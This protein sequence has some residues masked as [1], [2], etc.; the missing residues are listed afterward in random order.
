M[1]TDVH[2]S[3]LAGAPP[4][5][6]NAYRIAAVVL[7]LFALGHTRGALL[8]TPRFGPA[9]DAVAAAMKD[10]HLAAA[11]ASD[12]T[13]YGFY[14]GFGII[15]SVFFL[16]SAVLAWHL[17][18]KTARERAGLWP[19]SAALVASYAANLVIT[20]LYFFPAPTVFSAAVTLL[21]GWGLAS[22]LRAGPREGSAKVA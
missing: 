22:D 21:L 2:A 11:G 10:V 14:L 17:G 9:S 4:R 16:L 1:E 3:P 6:I 12:C 15:V 19:V 18:G 13:W 5:R 20:R 7:V 8:S